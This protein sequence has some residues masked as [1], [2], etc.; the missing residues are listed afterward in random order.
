MVSPIQWLIGNES[1]INYP[2]GT[3]DFGG[4]DKNLFGTLCSAAYKTAIKQPLVTLID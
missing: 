4:K 2:R 3:G 1:S